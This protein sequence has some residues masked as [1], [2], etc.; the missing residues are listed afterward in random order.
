[1]ADRRRDFS[2]RLTRGPRRR[3]RIMIHTAMSSGVLWWSVSCKL[4][5]CGPRGGMQERERAQEAQARN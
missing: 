2:S 5:G 1:M 3:G 4:C